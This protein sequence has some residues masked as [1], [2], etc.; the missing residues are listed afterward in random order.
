[1]REIVTRC[2]DPE[3]NQILTPG[4]CPECGEEQMIHENMEICWLCDFSDTADK[5]HQAN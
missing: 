1:M 3:C 5:F 2:D 4:K